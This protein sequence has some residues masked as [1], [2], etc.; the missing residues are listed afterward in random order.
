[1]DYFNRWDVPAREELS[2]MKTFD[3]HASIGAPCYMGGGRTIRE[4]AFCIP[5]PEPCFWHWAFKYKPNGRASTDDKAY[6][7]WLK[8]RRKEF[9]EA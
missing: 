7:T 6:K 9:E 8:R 1:M 4:E 3:E 5:C 2:R